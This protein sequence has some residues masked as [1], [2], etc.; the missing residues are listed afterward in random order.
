[1]QYFERV[2]ALQAVTVELEFAAPGYLPMRCGMFQP[3]KPLMTA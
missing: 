1:M 2:T 3:V